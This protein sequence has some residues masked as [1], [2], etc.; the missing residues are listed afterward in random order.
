MIIIYCGNC[1]TLLGQCKRN[2]DRLC[3]QCCS[4]T[5][6]ARPLL[7]DSG[8]LPIAFLPSSEALT[9]ALRCVVK[10]KQGLDRHP[11]RSL[12]YAN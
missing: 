10:T 3:K 2:I 6:R 4:A 9:D 8:R 11:A 1:G 7:R 5:P 12:D